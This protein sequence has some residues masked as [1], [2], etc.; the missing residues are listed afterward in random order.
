M[1]KN[2][3]SL[4][5]LDMGS[6]KLAVLLCEVTPQGLEVAGF[7]QSRSQGIRKGAIVSIEAAVSSLKEAL[8]E[9][10]QLAQREIN[11]LIVGV[12]GSH[13]QVLPSHGMVPIRDREI[14]RSDIEKVVEAA[15]TV[16]LPLDRELIQILPRDFVL[17]GQEGVK[18]PEGMYGRRL[19]ANTQLITGSVTTLQN[20][21]RC[22]DKASIK[23]Y[24]FFSNIVAS[25]RAVVGREEREA[26]VCVVDIGAATTDIA[27]FQDDTLSWIKTLSVG[28]AHL[29]NDLAVGLKTSLTEAERLKLQ[30][31]SVSSEASSDEIEIPGVVGDEPR[32]ID[33]SVF[34]MILQPRLEEILQMV[35]NELAKQGVD[36]TLPSGVVFT[37]GTAQLRGLLEAAGRVFRVPVRLGRPSRLGG[38]SEMIS[39]PTY[40][41]LV[42]L[43]QLGYEQSDELRFMTDYFEKKGVRRLQVQVARWLKDFF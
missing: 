26:G 29:T 21:R 42:G 20:I 9:A 41:T 2:Y 22:L 12:S 27:V 25:A 34:S 30:Y 38:L 15:A 8:G 36:E 37:G 31:G 4:A 23:N 28:G 6:E 13:I 14:R 24:Q 39:S 11:Y 19:E 5:A 7:G 43:C 32:R 17:D 33:R 1:A 10:R 40:A 35:R 16:S 18:E 3:P